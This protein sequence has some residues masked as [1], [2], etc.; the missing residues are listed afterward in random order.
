MSVAFV[1]LRLRN[2]EPHKQQLL[3]YKSTSL[4]FML[5]KAQK[6]SLKNSQFNNGLRSGH[7]K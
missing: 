7:N 5:E 3:S 2:L 4:Y 6:L 1:N